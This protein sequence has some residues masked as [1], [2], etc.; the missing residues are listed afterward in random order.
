[1]N[2]KNDIN[3]QVA[4][5]VMGWVHVKPESIGLHRSNPS[6][7]YTKAAHEN[8]SNDWVCNDNAFNPLA[9]ADDLKLV[10]DKMI[11]DGYSIHINYH[12]SIQE[13]DC[14]LMGYN[15]RASYSVGTTEN[16]AVCL[17]ALAAIEQDNKAG[18]APS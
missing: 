9:D 3:R 10:K 13:W 11:E 2:D 1:M 5:K 15:K 6:A 18:I 17:A 12:F 4:E 7:Y 8:M 16:E 14:E